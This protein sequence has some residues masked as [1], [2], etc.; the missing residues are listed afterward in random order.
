ML[1]GQMANEWIVNSCGSK[2]DIVGLRVKTKLQKCTLQI[3]KWAILS[4]EE[5]MVLEKLVGEKFMIPCKNI[6]PWFTQ[7]KCTTDIILISFVMQIDVTM[8]ERHNTHLNYVFLIY[9]S[10]DEKFLRSFIDFIPCL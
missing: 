6:H 9:K 4:G 8:P 3:Y 5:F 10:K 7:S 1:Q 2:Q